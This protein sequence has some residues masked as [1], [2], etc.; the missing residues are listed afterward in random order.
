[1]SLFNNVFNHTM[2]ETILKLK[3]P[4]GTIFPEPDSYIT[5][6]QMYAFWTLF[7]GIAY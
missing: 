4:S 5:Y 2:A 1:M 7:F 3:D 6:L